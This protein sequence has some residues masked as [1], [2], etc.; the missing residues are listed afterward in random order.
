MEY[1]KYQVDV[2]SIKVEPDTEGCKVRSLLQ[3]SLNKISNSKNVT[4]I[5]MNPSKA[6]QKSS[7]Q[8]INRIIDFFYNEQTL[9][10]KNIKVVNL[11]SFYNPK[12]ITLHEN[13]N[14]SEEKLS[15]LVQNNQNVIGLS[16]KESDYVFLGWG[17]SPEG[18]YETAFYSQVIY[19][20]AEIKRYKEKK[21]FVFKIDN[22]RANS[23]ETLTKSK[24]PVHP[25]NGPILDKVEVKIDSLYRILPTDNKEILDGIHEL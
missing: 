10:V 3:L 11:F 6:N 25:I 8:T 21:T 13:V 12:S 15:L 24:N 7:D 20:L 23:Q 14:L 2:D 18:F 19:V 22:K 1:K 4:I 17:N 9:N 16:I 5:M